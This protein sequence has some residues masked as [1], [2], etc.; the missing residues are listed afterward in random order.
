MPPTNY[1]V[2]CIVT[3]FKIDANEVNLVSLS[4]SLYHFIPEYIEE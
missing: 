4:K 2:R 3:N 1:R